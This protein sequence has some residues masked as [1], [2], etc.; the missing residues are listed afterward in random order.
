MI[1]IFFFVCSSSPSLHQINT[2]FILCT[3]NH[4]K[5][6]FTEIYTFKEIVCHKL[7]LFFIS[8]LVN[9]SFTNY[10]KHQSRNHLNPH[11]IATFGPKNIQLPGSR[12]FFSMKSYEDAFNTQ[13]SKKIKIN[14]SSNNHRKVIYQSCSIMKS[15]LQRR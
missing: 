6:L 1:L 14:E 15:K 5:A 11:Y 12:H 10:S 7:F 8:S 3:R 4:I 9:I 2:D 13:H